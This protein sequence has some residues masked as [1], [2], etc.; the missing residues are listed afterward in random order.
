MNQ[1]GKIEKFLRGKNRSLSVAQAHSL[2]KIGSLTKRISEMRKAGLK[3]ETIIGKDRKAKYKIEA[4]DVR[5]S[6]KTK[7]YTEK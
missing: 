6:T 4:K 3:I 1:N 7:F 5:G 2:F